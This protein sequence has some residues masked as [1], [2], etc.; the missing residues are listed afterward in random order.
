MLA[1]YQHKL[2]VHLFVHLHDYFLADENPQTVPCHA[3]CNPGG[4]CATRRCRKS[5]NVMDN[6]LL[7][8]EHALDT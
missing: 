3:S 7:G 8:L 4:I 2:L 1:G 6:H 5:A